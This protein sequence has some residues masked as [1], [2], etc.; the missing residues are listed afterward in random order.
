M[1]H[2][3]PSRQFLALSLSLTVIGL[4]FGGRPGLAQTGFNP[5]APSPTTGATAGGATGGF[6]PQQFTGFVQS[7]LKQLDAL[8][9][10]V[11]QIVQKIT[12]SGSSAVSKAIQDALGDLNLPDPQKLLANLTKSLGFD[13]DGKSQTAQPNSISG[14]SP[15]IYTD[16]QTASLPA[17]V[18]SQA[19]FSSD[20]QSAVKQ[21][22]QSIQQKVSALPQTVNGSTQLAN[23]ST[24]AAQTA[25]Q[26]ATTA[27]QQ[28]KQAQSRV[29]TQDAIK[30][31]NLTAGSIAGQLGALSSQSAAQSGQLAN[32]TAL[33]ATSAGFQGDASAKLSQVNLGVA[34]AVGQLADLNEQSRGSEQLRVIQEQALADQLNASSSHG[35]NLLR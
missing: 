22:L 17:K 14:I 3:V 28:A 18:F 8:K 30:D 11:S 9:D 26:G 29:S 23:Q 7:Y 20:A 21:D 27:Q 15:S 34:A 1:F 35:F 16:N 32:L 31:L 6:D 13:Q 10:Q 5:G 25:N 33:G 19:N 12:S 2:S 24:Q 4:N